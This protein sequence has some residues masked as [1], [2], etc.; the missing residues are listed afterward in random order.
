M[1]PIGAN[2]VKKWLER[3][4]THLTFSFLFA[5]FGVDV[6][7]SAVATW[8]ASAIQKTFAPPGLSAQF[9]F[10]IGVLVFC[11]ITLF[12]ILVWVMKESMTPISSPQ[13][14]SSTS[15]L[16]IHSAY[17]GIPSINEENVIMSIQRLCADALVIQ[18]ENNTF[19]CDPVQNL[20]GKRLRVKYSYGNDEVREVSLPEHSR[21][22]LPEAFV[23][24]QQAS[25]VKY[26]E[27]QIRTMSEKGKRP[28]FPSGIT[29]G[30]RPTIQSWFIQR[31]WER[32]VARGD[33]DR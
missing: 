21:M 29:S 32:R 28:E 4:I 10:V 3:G 9:Y 26:T 22:V 8:T 23:F 18:V 15:R 13:P 20:P 31:V 14:Q 12:S 5:F 16:T 27:E 30:A 7:V 11:A 2:P 24:E 19:G 25:P 17:Y 1:D 6:A 33:G